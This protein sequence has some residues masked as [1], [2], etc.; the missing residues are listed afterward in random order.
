VGKSEGKRPI[1][2]PKLKWVNNFKMYFREMG[3]LVWS[4]LIWLRM[5][6]IGG[7]L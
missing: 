3:Q 4:G 2:G 1:G 6:T 7:L 5:E